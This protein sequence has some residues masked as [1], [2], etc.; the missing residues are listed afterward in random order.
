[1][2]LILLIL[3]FPSMTAASGFSLL[4][5]L[6]LC[7][8]GGLHLR[9]GLLDRPLKLLDES[10]LLIGKR[11]LLKSIHPMGAQQIAHDI[12]MS[13]IKPTGSHITHPFW[14]LD[15]SIFVYRMFGG[16]T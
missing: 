16:E 3:P 1:M 12:L 2:F 7:L 5:L 10:I 9:F 6:A 11:C 15:F 14:A 13:G 8:R 4:D